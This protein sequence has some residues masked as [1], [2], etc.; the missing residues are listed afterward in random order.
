MTAKEHWMSAV[1]AYRPTRSIPFWAFLM[2]AGLLVDAVALTALFAL[3]G[4]DAGV[5]PLNRA[6]L[7]VTFAFGTG[8][9]TIGLGIPMVFMVSRAG[10]VGKAALGSH[11]VVLGTTLFVILVS[12]TPP[13]IYGVMTSVTQLRTFQGFL[14]AALSVELTLIGASYLRLIQSGQT[15]WRELGFDWQRI[16]PDIIRGLGYGVVAFIV[17]ALIQS[18][19]D[20]VGIRQTQLR[21][22]GWIRDLDLSGFLVV[23]ALGAIG[24]PLAEELYFRGYV[25]ASYLREKGPIVAYVVSGVVFAGLHMNREALLPIFILGMMLA[26][27]YRRSKSIVP[28]ITAH[29]LNNG[30]AFLIFY[31]GPTLGQ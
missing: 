31:F 29:A 26:W 1:V 22:L 14:L 9:F 10:S 6:I 27:M 30:L 11:R 16:G 3:R 19:L 20:L 15:T 23:F 18:G 17:S 7:L 12:H 25:F 28:S 24:A 13:T 4:A 21:E 2:G 8:V 5:D